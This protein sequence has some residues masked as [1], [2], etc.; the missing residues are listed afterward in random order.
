[1]YNIIRATED[2]FKKKKKKSSKGGN[3]QIQV[4]SFKIKITATPSIS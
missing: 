3:E 2:A 4:R 1:M